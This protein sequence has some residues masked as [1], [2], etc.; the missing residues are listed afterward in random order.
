[1]NWRNLWIPMALSG[2]LYLSF[3]A[4]GWWGF[5]LV[6]SGVIFWLLQHTT[7]L[8]RTMERAAEQPMGVV[9]N[10]V[11]FH[12]QLHK[13]MRL[14]QV[15]GHAGSLGKRVSPAGEQPEVF[16]WHDASG[17]TVSCTFQEGR[18]TDWAM[19]RQA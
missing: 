6:S 17:D 8:M 7:R 2:L 19:A 15:I 4:F 1:M 18:L 12:S 14:L 9:A 11:M 10:A 3:R 16:T 13:G 5:S